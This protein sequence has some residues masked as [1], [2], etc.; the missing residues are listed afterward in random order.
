MSAGGLI[1][2][3]AISVGNSMVTGD[4]LQKAIMMQNSGN[5]VIVYL[6]H[7][8]MKSQVAG[9]LKRHNVHVISLNCFPPAT[10][11]LH[12]FLHEQRL[13]KPISSL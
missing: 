3:Q 6:T 10:Y 11:D 12:C 13:D 4:F 5:L 8:C 2:Y 7:C 9:V 1:V